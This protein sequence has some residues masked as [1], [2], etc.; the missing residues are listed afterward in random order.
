VIK[1]VM[2][3]DISWSLLLLRTPS[4]DGQN[5]YAGLRLSVSFSKYILGSQ[6]STEYI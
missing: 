3:L 2:C 6:Q 4:V 5:P 1:G